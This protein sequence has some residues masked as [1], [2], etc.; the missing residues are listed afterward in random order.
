MI[1]SQYILDI[2]NLLLDQEGTENAKNQIQYLTDADY[3][4]TGAGVYITFKATENI[5]EDY[6]SK[7]SV[8][9]GINIESKELEI[10]AT[11]LVFCNHGII[12]TLEIAAY[13]ELYPKK[14][15]TDYTLLLDY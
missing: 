14:N 9:K 5:K 7:K 6:L 3:N 2:L 4:Y 13:G 12:E 10:G 1:K 15:L 11:A 8:I